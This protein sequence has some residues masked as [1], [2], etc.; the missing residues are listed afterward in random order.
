M[1]RLSIVCLAV[2]CAA[3]AAFGANAAAGSGN[4]PAS[5]GNWRIR[6]G[7][8]R[9]LGIFQRR[10]RQ[11]M[12]RHLHE[13][14]RRGRFQGRVRQELR[15][16]VSAGRRHRRLEF[17]RQRSV[18]GCSMRRAR[19]WSNSARWKT[20]STRR[21]RRASACCSCRMPPRRR[22][23]RRRRRTKWPATGCSCAGTGTPL[24]G[25]T[26]AAT[27]LRDGL[28]L[29]VKPGCAPSIAQLNF[30]QWQLDHDEL[31]LMPRAATP[32]RF[33]EIDNVSWR[34]FRKAPTRSRWSSR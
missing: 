25:L 18:C 7:G 12:H 3:G 29:T 4:T 19:R 33:E 23:L 17:P 14:T 11:E 24:C 15:H 34:G 16:A 31:V 28:A 10:P 20:E 5:T 22:V 6:Q 9:Q 13:R 27:P 1:I 30:T 26:L 21:R 2:I 8:D 32:W